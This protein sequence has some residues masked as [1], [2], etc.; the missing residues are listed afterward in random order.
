MPAR[1]ALHK[2]HITYV[3]HTLW[4]HCYQPIT[5]ANSSPGTDR[6]VSVAESLLEIAMHWDACTPHWVTA[7][8]HTLLLL[9]TPTNTPS[10][11]ER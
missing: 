10:A 1:P 9:T 4:N 6:Y 3:A 5:Q 11:Q 8:L 2:V 7:A